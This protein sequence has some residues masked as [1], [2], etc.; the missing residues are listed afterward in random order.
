[1]RFIV[2]LYLSLAAFAQVIGAEPTFSAPDKEQELAARME[3]LR[4]EYA[5]YLRSL[6]KKV[7]V[8]LQ[9]GSGKLPSHCRPGQRSQ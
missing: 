6:P 1:M 3:Q 2:W 4:S 5:L 9:T 8:Y 7:D